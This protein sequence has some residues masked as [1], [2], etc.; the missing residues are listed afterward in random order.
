V[1]TANG[2]PKYG[3]EHK[4]LRKQLERVVRAGRASCWRCGRPIAPVGDPWHP[5]HRDDGTHAG[6]ECQRCNLSD[7]ARRGH[8]AMIAAAVAAAHA[9]NGSARTV[10]AAPVERELPPGRWMRAYP[11]GWPPDPDP[12]NGAVSWSGHWWTA[13]EFNPRCPA[14]PAAGRPCADARREED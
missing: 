3:N 4:R 12:R 11:P 14:C 9:R 1:K 10:A 2:A 13:G 8:R 6:V 7:G 5:G